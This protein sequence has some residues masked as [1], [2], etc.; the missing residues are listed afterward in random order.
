MSTDAM[1]ADGRAGERRRQA[2]S[3]YVSPSIPG[4]VLV[5]PNRLA[6]G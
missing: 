4:G 1:R 3:S 2:S 5:L 6:V